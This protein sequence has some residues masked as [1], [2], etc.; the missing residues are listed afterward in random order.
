MYARTLNYPVDNGGTHHR[1]ET[2]V[3]LIPLGKAIKNLPDLLKKN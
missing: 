1:F 3:G 2:S